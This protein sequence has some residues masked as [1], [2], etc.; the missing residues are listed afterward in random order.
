MVTGSIAKRWAKALFMLAEEKRQVAET[1]GEVER[2]ADAWDSSEEFREA[3]TNPMLGSDVQR[4]IFDEVVKKAAVSKT[5]GNF[6]QL[7]LDKGRLQEISNISRELKALSDEKARR[8]R[9]TVSSAFPM[10]EKA[11]AKL[12]ETIEKSFGKEVIIKKETD[13]SLIGGVVTKV[14]GLMYDGSVKSGLNKIK[15]EM[16]SER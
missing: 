14:A 6:F 15:E 16:R 13:E 2:V 8:I 5:V 11:L 7:L 3:M 12:R 1:A 9:A 4:R 10:D